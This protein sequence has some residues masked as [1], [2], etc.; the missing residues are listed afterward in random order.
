MHGEKVEFSLETK[1]IGAFPMSPSDHFDV[2]HNGKLIYVYPQP[3]QR[4]TVK[5]VCFLDKLN[6]KK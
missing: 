6:A 5:G 2:Y 4:M 1:K 3:D